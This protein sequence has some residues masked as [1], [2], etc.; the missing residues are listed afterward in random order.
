MTH[1]KNFIYKIIEDKL[2]KVDDDN[3]Q[4]CQFFDAFGILVQFILFLI[5]ISFLL[6][7]YLY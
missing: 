6:G 7:K 2:Q 5:C 4:A 3:T 1:P